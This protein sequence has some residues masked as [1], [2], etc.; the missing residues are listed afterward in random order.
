MKKTM[1]AAVAL[2]LLTGAS[3]PADG[4]G[5]DYALRLAVT[6]AP[7][8]PLQRID[9]PAQALAA[10]R[11]P[12]RAD[13]RVF[14]RDGTALPMALA[15]PAGGRAKLRTLRL[16]AL[17]IRGPAGALAAD[18]AAL[19]VE[20]RDGDQVVTVIQQGAADRS[21]V[22][23]GAL[24]DTRA[25]DARGRRLA[26]DI[27]L[28]PEQPVDI[29]VESSPDLTSWTPIGGK[30]LYRRG[31]TAPA[32]LG[33][34]AIALGDAELRDRYLRIS[35][36]SPQKLLGPVELRGALVEVAERLD[37]AERPSIATSPPE[38][39]DAHDIRFTLPHA[40]PI[41][42]IAIAPAAGEML[43]PV[44]ILGRNGPDQGW[45]PLGSGVV[46]AGDQAPIELSGLAFRDYRIEVDQ[47]TPGFA[48]PPKLRLSFEPARIALLFD[49]KPP[50]RLAVGSDIAEGRYLP[51]GQLIAD[52][53][54]GAE[55]KLSL[56]TVATTPGA[57]LALA[58]D[59]D[60]LFSPR[61]T[62]LWSLLL[63]GVMAL[64]WMVWRLWR[65]SNSSPERGGG[66]AA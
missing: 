17:P 24:L 10:L 30:T 2:L 43:A 45:T 7:G 34:E 12:S 18:G 29:A 55:D 32:A 13:V 35:W 44:R 11:R 20:R 15:A 47:R 33:P 50:Y 27:T 16:E 6:P 1:I 22:L 64:A 26:L 40:A 38:R 3:D 60:S 25:L 52:Y 57:L 28:P 53:R 4:P 46:R 23:L 19:K 66:P 36:T 61:K 51:I 48:A 8:A 39:I 42:G 54:T 58:A 31:G 62:V 37:R 65:P 63:I 49:G 14:D 21:P 9:L 41:A 56:A 5:A 59:D